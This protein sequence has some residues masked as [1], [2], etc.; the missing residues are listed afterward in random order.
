M[1]QDTH[2]FAHDENQ[3][4]LIRMAKEIADYFRVYPEEKA[5]ESI[6][7]HI[8]H[9]WTPK[10]RED[11]LAAASEPGQALPPLVAAAREKIARKKAK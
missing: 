1:N 9:F 7:S 10:M 6:A 5:V 2:T 11:F 3:A 8:N 4:R